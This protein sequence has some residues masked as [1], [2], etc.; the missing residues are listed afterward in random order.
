MS[1]PPIYPS[2]PVVVADVNSLQAWAVVVTQIL[3]TLM[4][5]TG[6]SGWANQVIIT[7]QSAATQQQ[8]VGSKDGDLWVAMP[9]QAGQGLGRSIWQNGAWVS[10]N[11]SW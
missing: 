3:N 8:P 9:T 2:L 11:G 1:N 4:G 10:L 5:T 6:K 7:Q